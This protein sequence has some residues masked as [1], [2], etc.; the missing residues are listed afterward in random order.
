MAYL[1]AIFYFII[2]TILCTYFKGD[3]TTCLLTLCVILLCQIK[4]KEK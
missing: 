3:Y 1:E 2:G 4:N